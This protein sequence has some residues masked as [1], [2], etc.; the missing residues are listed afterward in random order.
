[1][2]NSISQATGFAAAAHTSPV[3]PLPPPT[4][5]RDGFFKHHG[6]WAPGVRLF[7]RIG[8]NAKAAIIT[9]TFLLPIAVLGWQYFN[10]QADQIA[11]SAKELEGSAYAREAYALLPALLQARNQLVMPPSAAE[12]TATQA[13]LQD[14][15]AR[16]Q[17]MNDSHGAALSTQATHD[18]LVQAMKAMPAPTATSASAKVDADLRAASATIHAL[19]DLIG[20]ASDG[21]NLT[22]DPDIDT[23]Y[24]MDTSMFKLPSMIE[25]AGQ[26]GAIGTKVLSGGQASAA[27][28]RQ[29]VE[30]VAILRSGQDGVKAGL[31]KVKAYNPAVQDA[32][33]DQDADRAVRALTDLI[34]SAVLQAQPASPASGPGAQGQ[35]QRVAKAADQAVAAMLRLNEEAAT[36]L[37]AL[38]AARVGKLASSRNMTFVL[39]CLCLM[40]ALYLFTSFR[41]VLHGGLREVAFHIDQMRDGDLTTVP[42]AWGADEAAGLIRSLRQMRDA[43]QHLVA[44]VRQAADGIVVASGEIASGAHDLSGRTEQSATHLQKTAT[45]M[46]EIS[47]GVHH[48]E[49]AM[50]RAAD[51]AKGNVQAAQHSGQVVQELVTRMQH[52]DGSATRINDIIGTIEGIAFQTNIL[53]LNA[54]VEAARAGEH[55]RGF[56]VVAAEVRAL[57]KRSSDAAREIKVLI[58][59]S[60]QQI[61]G[62]MDVANQAG[63]LMANVVDTSFTVTQC[64]SE[65]VTGA[66]E[67]TH[68]IAS[69]TLAVQQLDAATQQNAA[70]VEQTAAAASAL[71]DQALHLVAHVARY[72]LPGSTA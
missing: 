52:I 48:N 69:T 49:S 45:A 6:L 55:G 66:R 3:R 10:S 54:A 5:R 43:M 57:A 36:S 29:L 19:I 58:S 30:Q 51:I 46:T 53:A 21:S 63:G 16:L 40:A 2:H 18:A 72:K 38:I 32:V 37:D 44:H 17:A 14:R 1:M 27:D 59:D 20:V 42:H 28:L 39:V 12:A 67:Q 25:A 61:Q 70:L 8:F 31:G 7:R 4:R 60:T 35:P 56:A 62:G 68:G 34:E 33:H 9:L 13:L 11:F 50:T 23:Y 15:R 41:K 24:L 47:T 22:L 65:A 64:L 26:V 71:N